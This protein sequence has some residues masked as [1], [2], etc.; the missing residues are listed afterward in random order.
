VPPHVALLDVRLGTLAGTDATLA[1]RLRTEAPPAAEWNGTGVV[2]PPANSKT[3]ATQAAKHGT[4]LGGD[5][6]AA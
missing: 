2:Y 1:R 6:L 5:G 3:P 4:C